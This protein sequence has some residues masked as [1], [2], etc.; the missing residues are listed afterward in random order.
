[1]SMSQRW[2]IMAILLLILLSIHWNVDTRFPSSFGFADARSLDVSTQKQ[3]IIEVLLK[4]DKG[5]EA[6]KYGA[7]AFEIVYM[8]NAASSSKR[9]IFVLF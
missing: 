8:S 1:M 3:R 4:L 2:L 6:L 5:N 7:R 9:I